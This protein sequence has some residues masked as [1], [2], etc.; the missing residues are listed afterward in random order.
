MA[1]HSENVVYDHP[2]SGQ[3]KV[4]ITRR[5]YLY[6]TLE[7]HHARFIQLIPMIMSNDVIRCD[8]EFGGMFGVTTDGLVYFSKSWCH[9]FIVSRRR[10]GNGLAVWLFNVNE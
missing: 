9:S 3:E 7:S 10:N 4:R 8:R 2:V 5:V 1:S 6:M